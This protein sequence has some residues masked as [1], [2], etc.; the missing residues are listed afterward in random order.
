[1]GMWAAS[2]CKPGFGVELLRDQKI[3]TFWQSD[4]APPHSIYVIFPR[5]MA[6]CELQIYL[7]HRLDESYTPHRVRILAGLHYH[8]LHEVAR[9]EWQQPAGWMSIPLN[10]DLDA[11]PDSKDE[12]NRTYL[13]TFMLQI[14]I[15]ANQQTG[16][17][18]HVRLIHIYGPKP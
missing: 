8:D 9:A 11:P 10:N 3:D 15:V 4:G 5:R 12:P 14:M 6:L 17:D 7:D 2:S 13:E 1:M 16:R 18:S